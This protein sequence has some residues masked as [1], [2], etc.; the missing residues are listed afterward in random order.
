M[1]KKAMVKDIKQLSFLLYSR[2]CITKQPNKCH[3]IAE[4]QFLY[5]LYDRN[6]NV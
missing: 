6:M 2:V 4:Y 5:L 3:S 1:D